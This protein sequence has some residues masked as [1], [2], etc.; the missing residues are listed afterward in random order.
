MQKS[1]AVALI[2][3]TSTQ[4]YIHGKYS[5]L[6][7]KQQDWAN[8][9]FTPVDIEVDGQT[10]TLYYTAAMSEQAS[11]DEVFIAPSRAY[12]T[13]F[14]Q[15]DMTNPVYWTPNLLNGYVEYDIDLS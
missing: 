6:L 15:L 7:K 12:L 4:A 11:S 1:L 3:A 2:G 5:N 9:A 14:A 8:S 10:K 13:E